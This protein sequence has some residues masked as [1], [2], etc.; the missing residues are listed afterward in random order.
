MVAL[1]TNRDLSAFAGARAVVGREVGSFPNR[2]CSNDL[3][4]GDMH[5]NNTSKIL[6]LFTG[7]RNF[8]FTDSLSS[9][10]KLGGSGIFHYSRLQLRWFFRASEIRSRSILR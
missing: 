4:T 6:L 8:Q 9:K 7:D 1:G 2:D 3:G 5:P 10:V